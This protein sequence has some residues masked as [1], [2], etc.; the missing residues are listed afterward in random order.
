MVEVRSVG[1]I[2]HRFRKVLLS[3]ETRWVFLLFDGGRIG[4]SARS[5]ALI[6]WRANPRQRGKKEHPDFSSTL[7]SRSI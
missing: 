5:I 2:R 7:I 1:S 3:T 4:L 6:A